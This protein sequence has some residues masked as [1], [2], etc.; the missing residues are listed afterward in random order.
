MGL[1][2]NVVLQWIEEN[3]EKLIH[4][5]QEL[6]KIPSITGNEKKVQ[7]FLHDKLKNLGMKSELVFPDI[8]ELRKHDDYFVT[9]S[10]EKSGYEDRPN[11]FA[12]LKGEGTGK[13]MCLSGHVDVVSAEPLGD[14]TK[15][16]WGGE[17]E[18]NYIY[19]RGSG[20][21]KAGVAALLI[22]VRAL[23]ETGTTLKG[24]LFLETTIEEEDGGVGG[25]L[26]LR[27]IKPK[28]DA[29][30][31]PEPSDY[32]IGLASAGV[33]Y[34]RVN[35]PGLTA[36]AAT[37]HF[38]ENAIIKALPIINA[39]K[40]LNET[41]QR[42]IQYPLVE[43]YPSMKGR[44]TTINIG[45][46]KAGDWPSTVPGLCT[47][48][49]RVGWPPG[50]SRE[51]VVNQIETVIMDATQKDPWLKDHKPLVEWFGWRAR[52]HEQD[53]N[54]PFVKL[55]AKYSSKITKIQPYYSGGSA[56][57][58]T[59]YFVHHGS[60]AVVYGPMAERIHSFDERVSID[61]TVNV[62][63]VIAATVLEWC[64]TL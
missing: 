2:N 1:N 22:V 31:I 38:G 33:M 20:D 47:L 21:M 29:A 45:V 9:T 17:V 59:R 39:L 64:G 4:L 40:G 23:K 10:F 11:V 63:K 36:H 56:G 46:I 24:N 52:P 34:F 12:T 51:T 60:P 44:A 28:P 43:Q 54:D 18:G 27:M 26:W 55:V 14:W 62:A 41:R 61:S 57:L 37:A 25:N 16:P 5:T 49:C 50:E 19:G 8:N 35:I 42:T 3:S 32:V 53:R 58:D 30:I 7:L 48:E 13:S 6:V 15:D